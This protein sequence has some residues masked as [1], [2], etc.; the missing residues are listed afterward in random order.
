MSFQVNLRSIMKAKD[1]TAKDLGNLTGLSYRTIEGWLSSQSKIPRVDI[2]FSVA[3]ALNV[4]LEYLVT[5]K[6]NTQYK[7]QDF[8]DDIYMK[9]NI[10]SYGEKSIIRELCNEASKLSSSRIKELLEMVRVFQKLDEGKMA[11]QA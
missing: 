5:G 11:D 10:V 8:I 3:E 9:E 1:I 4:S 7:R 2:A 6:E